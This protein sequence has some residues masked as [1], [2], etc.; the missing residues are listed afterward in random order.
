[1][2][3]ATVAIWCDVNSMITGSEDVLWYRKT[4]DS[5]QVLGQSSMLSVEFHEGRYKM[6]LSKK[7]TTSVTYELIISCEFRV[8]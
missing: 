5:K 8:F 1:M 6:S 2:V 4:G 7:T 3:N